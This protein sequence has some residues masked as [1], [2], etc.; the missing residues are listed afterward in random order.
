LPV[1]T[2]ALPLHTR[3]FALAQQVAPF[4]RLLE[5]PATP[6]EIESGIE[7]RDY[8]HFMEGKAA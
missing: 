8:D 1:L 6:E 7:Y 2:L 5:R 4:A 3:V